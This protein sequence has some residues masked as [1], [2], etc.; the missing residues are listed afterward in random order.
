MNHTTQSDT[1]SS[2]FSITAKQ[3]K[4]A[5]KKSRKSQV[6]ADSSGGSKLVNSARKTQLQP[7][8]AESSRTSLVEVEGA[9][10]YR[11]VISDDIITQAVEVD[12]F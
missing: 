5:K 3:H 6:N 11:S 12:G 9:I 8:A 7:A 1:N 4:M 10:E 2:S